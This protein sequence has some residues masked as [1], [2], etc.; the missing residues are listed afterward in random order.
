M[1]IIVTGIKTCFAAIIAI[2]AASSACAAVIHCGAYGKDDIKCAIIRTSRTT[3]AAISGITSRT[4]RISRTARTVRADSSRDRTA[5]RISSRTSRTIS[6]RTDA[7]IFSSKGIRNTCS[8]G[9]TY[10]LF[11]SL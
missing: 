1:K 6:I 11:I 5:V 4:I 7:D 2:V 10:A 9:I 3:A 8:K